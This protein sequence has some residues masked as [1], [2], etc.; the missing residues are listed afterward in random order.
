[1]HHGEILTE[2]S[3]L[4]HAGKMRPV[5]DERNFSLETI[6]EAYKAMEDGSAKGKIVISINQE[7][8]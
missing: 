2:A 6:D 1:M 8:L 4:I 5:V 7:Y 3:K